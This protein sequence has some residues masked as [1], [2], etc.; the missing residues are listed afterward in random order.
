MRDLQPVAAEW[1]LSGRNRCHRVRLFVRW[2]RVR[3]FSIRPA[4][5]SMDIDFP[6]WDFYPDNIEVRFKTKIRA[7]ARRGQWRR[8]G[9]N[10]HSPRSESDR[11]CRRAAGSAGVS[12]GPVRA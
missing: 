11:A 3:R 10:D 2:P 5:G 1:L 12:L 9:R 4:V 8:K 7:N 6:E